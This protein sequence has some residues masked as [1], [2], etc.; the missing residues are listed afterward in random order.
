MYSVTPICSKYISSMKQ[1]YTKKTLV[2]RSIRPVPQGR[3]GGR[4][5]QVSR[6]AVI[7]LLIVLGVSLYPVI[8]SFVVPM[9]LAAAFST[10][11]Y[12]LYS[13]MLKIF[14]HNRLLGALA[15]CLILVLCLVTPL[16]I[17]MHLVVVES[18]HFYKEVGPAVKNLVSAGSDSPLFL[19]ISRYLPTD[20]FTVMNV[21]LT[22]VLNDTVKTIASFASMAINKTSAGVFGL[23]TNVVVMFFTM[24]Y[25]FID[26]EAFVRRLKYLSPIRDDYEDLLFSRFLL[27]SRATVMGTIV[28]GCIQ[29]VIG[30]LTLLVFGVTSWML[31]GFVMIFLSIIP[32]VGAWLILI[33]AG[34]YQIVTGHVWQGIGII[35]ICV[36]VVSNIDNLLRPRMVGKGAK[37]HDLVIF[38]ASLGGIAAFGVLG[39]IVGPVIA[40]LFVSALDIYSIEFREQLR[41]AN[42]Q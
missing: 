31:W 11:F 26:G 29:G 5:R 36:V 2:R 20:L 19:T 13:K 25:F 6:Y 33:P 1:S 35:L 12:P 37:L 3:R 27:I 17:V 30:A 7:G 9:I 8:R 21:N 16:Y 38:F 10:L 14:R 41:A 4:S 15:T 34:V 39:F 28:I 18:L 32:M 40:A 23:L 22:G 24:F 42:K